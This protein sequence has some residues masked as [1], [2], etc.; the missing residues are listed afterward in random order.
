MPKWKGLSFIAA[1]VVLCTLVG[2]LAGGS[3]VAQTTI[4]AALMKD[5][6]NPIRQP[7]FLE[8]R[9]FADPGENYVTG[10]YAIDYVVPAGKR[11]VIEFV[12]IAAADLPASSET[13]YEGRIGVPGGDSSLDAFYLAMAQTSAGV[14]HADQPLRLYYAPGDH[15][16]LATSRLHCEAAGIGNLHA[17]ASGYLVDLTY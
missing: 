2:A 5:V 14:Y 3:L 1:G 11:L 12:S 4:R 13:I 7:V 8:G 10:S 9:Y 15:F 16:R 6:D 17:V